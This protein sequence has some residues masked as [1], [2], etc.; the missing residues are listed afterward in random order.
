MD[1]ETKARRD[2]MI[3]FHNVANYFPLVGSLE[4]KN[5]TLDLQYQ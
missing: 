3:L 2:L 1:K 4:P 5:Y